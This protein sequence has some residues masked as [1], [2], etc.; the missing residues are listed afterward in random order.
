MRKLRLTVCFMFVVSLVFSH[1]ISFAGKG[2][3]SQKIHS[4]VKSLF[5]EE[6]HPDDT[7]FKNI[8][9]NPLFLKLTKDLSQEELGLLANEIIRHSA[10]SESSPLQY[11]TKL[12]DGSIGNFVIYYTTE[13]THAVKNPENIHWPSFYST[14][15]TRVLNHR[16]LETFT[17]PIWAPAMGYR[18]L[19]TLL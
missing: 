3:T 16:G 17:L 11:Q 6:K 5:S 1:G 10:M 15:L 7:S 13:G 18:M 4:I 12:S 9:G 19:P 2:N 14:G 8:C